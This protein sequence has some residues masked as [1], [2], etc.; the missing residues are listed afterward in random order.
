MNGLKILN[1]IKMIGFTIICLTNHFLFSHIY[2][3]ENAFS[4]KHRLL[5]SGSP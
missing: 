4:I 1:L 3:L 2:C 5:I